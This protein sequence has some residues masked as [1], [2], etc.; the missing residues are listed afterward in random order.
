MPDQSEINLEA[1]PE[2]LR[3]AAILEK[4]MYI[5][6]LLLLVT[7]MIYIFGI[8]KPYIPLDKISDYWSLG[9]HD[10][11]KTTEIETGW[12]WLGMLMYADFL[13]FVPVA[14]LAGVTI[15]CFLS[16]FPMLLKGRDHVYAILAILEAI[17]L[18]LAA[19]GILT[20][21]H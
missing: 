14:V 20:V 9:V 6:L 15:I 5:G 21:G 13:N 16:I 10:Y 8:M 18:G 2:Q 19:S 3:Y 7:F 1:T 11:L 4:G 12:R 17:V